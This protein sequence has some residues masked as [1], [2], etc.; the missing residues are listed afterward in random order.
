MGVDSYLCDIQ[1]YEGQS[2]ICVIYNYIRDSQIYE[3][4]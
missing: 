3:G 2:V 4:K 1:L